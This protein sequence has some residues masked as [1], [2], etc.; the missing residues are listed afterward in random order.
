MLAK[1]MVAMPFVALGPSPSLLQAHAMVLIMALSVCSL[2]AWRSPIFSNMVHE[3][4]KRSGSYH[5]S[6]IPILIS[7]PDFVGANRIDIGMDPTPRPLGVLHH[8]SDGLK[9]R[10]IEQS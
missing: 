5:D 9:S 2:R 10:P 8:C 1:M 6:P 7:I 3:V 4:N